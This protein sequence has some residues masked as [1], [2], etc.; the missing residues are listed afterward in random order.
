MV[1]IIY[2]HNGELNNTSSGSGIRPIKMLEQLRRLP[3]EIEQVSGQKSERKKAIQHIQNRINEGV[4][5]TGVYVEN[6]TLP[7]G[8]EISKLPFL[9]FSIYKP[10]ALDHSFLEMLR[11]LEIPIY[12]FFRD[13]YWDF[14]EAFAGRWGR[15]KEQLILGLQKMYGKREIEFLK[16]EGV[17]PLFPSTPF[18]RFMENRFGCGGSI[19]PPGSSPLNVEKVTQ[20]VQG[21]SLFYVGGI[22]SMYMNADVIQDLSQITENTLL[23]I[24]CRELDYLREKDRF[25]TLSQAQFVHGSGTELMPLYQKANI[26]I[27][28]LK[29]VGYGGLSYSLKIAEYLCNGLPIIAFENT[30]CAEIIEQY[31]VGWIVPDIP[32]GISRLLRELGQNPEDIREKH[33]NVKRYGHLFTWE[34]RAKQLLKMMTE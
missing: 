8:L 3:I 4:V 30:V 9:P 12:Y 24:C 6:R 23:T 2:F 17:H 11:T 21:I 10:N 28:P 7:L 22:S 20:S 34:D 14:P 32:G 19:L 33:E 26:A 29:S 15:L 18:L 16:M 13:V 25:S 5:F 31:G 27:F 1:K